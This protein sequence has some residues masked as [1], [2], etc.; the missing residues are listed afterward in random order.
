MILYLEFTNNFS[1]HSLRGNLK[2][3][4]VFFSP[5][6]LCWMIMMIIVSCSV[7]TSENRCSHPRIRHWW[8]CWAEILRMGRTLILEKELMKETGHS[9]WYCF[10][11]KTTFTQIY[12][13]ASIVRRTMQVSVILHRYPLSNYSLPYSFLLIVVLQMAHRS[14]LQRNIDGAGRGD[15]FPG[16]SLLVQSFPSVPVIVGIYRGEFMQI[17]LLMFDFIWIVVVSVRLF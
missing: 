14:S 1:C 7:A 3:V 11:L 2:I 4:F 15:N 12:D 6:F 13:A 10:S 16:T 8:H 5:C 17:L 9:A